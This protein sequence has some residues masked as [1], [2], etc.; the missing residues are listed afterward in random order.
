MMKKHLLALSIGVALGTSPMT[1][2]AAEHNASA[3][4]IMQELEALKRKLQNDS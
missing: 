3:E 1:G 2:M 4:Q